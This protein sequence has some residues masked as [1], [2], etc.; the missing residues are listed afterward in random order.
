VATMSAYVI[1]GAVS[2]A[3]QSIIWE[4]I[5]DDP[6]LLAVV[7]SPEAIVFKNPTETARDSANRLSLWL[8]QVAEDEFTKNQPA[9]R[10]SPGATNGQAADGKTYQLH[11]PPLALNLYYLMTPFAPS[12]EADQMLL[13]KTMQVMY[14]NAIVLL[15]DKANQVFEE[16]RIILCRLSIEELTRIWEAL[17]EPYRLSVCY[18]VRVAR[19]SSVR[20]AQGVRVITHLNRLGMPPFIAPEERGE[21]IF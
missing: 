17:Q 21:P 10:L 19:V 9:Q 16:L 7:R 20:T 18:K 11:F 5:A 12:S 8:Y 14:D 1:L 4:S 15:Q 2:A 13:G 3:L 6:V